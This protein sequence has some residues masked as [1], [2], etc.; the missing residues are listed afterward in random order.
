MLEFERQQDPDSLR[1]RRDGKEIGF[2]QWHSDRGPRL[3]VNE[4]GITSFSI[5]ELRTILSKWE[6]IQVAINST[7]GGGLRGETDLTLSGRV[8]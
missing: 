7:R 8:V 6:E 3:V 2:L 4:P 5:P 1:I